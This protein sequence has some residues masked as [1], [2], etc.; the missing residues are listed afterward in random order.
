MMNTPNAIKPGASATAVAI[1]G[2]VEGAF[3][4][5]PPTTQAFENSPPGAVGNVPG[6]HKAAAGARVDAAMKAFQM[7]S[8]ELG[9]PEPS[10]EGEGTG[11]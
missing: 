10:K 11:K 1:E 3:A 6:A 7:T 4:N 8:T 2:R 9:M 5:D